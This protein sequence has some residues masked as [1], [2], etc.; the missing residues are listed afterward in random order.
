MKRRN[1][2]GKVFQSQS[3]T[4]GRMAVFFDL[5]NIH[6]CH[7]CSSQFRLVRLTW[8]LHCTSTLSNASVQK[9]E[10]W[11]DLHTV[12]PLYY[13]CHEMDKIDWSLVS[14]IALIC[15]HPSHNLWKVDQRSTYCQLDILESTSESPEWRALK[16]PGINA[17]TLVSIST[18]KDVQIYMQRMRVLEPLQPFPAVMHVHRLDPPSKFSPSNPNQKGCLETTVVPKL[19][20]TSSVAAFFPLWNLYDLLA[21]S[22]A[23]TTKDGCC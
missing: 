21:I 2:G 6:L 5:T 11:N 20:S 22:E 3:H 7:F 8:R 23:Q 17:T 4:N 13:F 15:T 16:W 14:T 19:R 12:N 9:E 18:V 10:I 1:K